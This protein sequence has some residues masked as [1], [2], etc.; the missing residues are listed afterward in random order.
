MAATSKIA[1]HKRP[2]P[3][4][5]HR[6]PAAPGHLPNPMTTGQGGARRGAT[7][8]RGPAHSH[9]NQETI[10]ETH[11]TPH[12][13]GLWRAGLRHRIAGGSPGFPAA[14][15][16]H[17]HRRLR[18]RR[19]RRFGRAA[20]RQEAQ[21]EHRPVHRGREQGRRG[22]QHRAPAGLQRPHRRQH[23]AVRLHRPAGDR[24]APHEGRLRPVQGSGADLGRRQLSERARGAQRPRRQQPGRIRGP[25]EEGPSRRVRVHRPGFRFAPRG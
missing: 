3:R 9:N 11:P 1:F 4:M 2:D 10:H 20:H 23:A 22:R 7:A 24:S 5:D 14:Q 16:R 25:G 17:A 6:A 15:T 12:P 21:R 19:R 13:A 18:P 8:V